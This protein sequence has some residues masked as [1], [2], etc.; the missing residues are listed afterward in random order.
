[1]G[2][3]TGHVTQLVDLARAFQRRGWD[4]RFAL[5]NPDALWTLAPELAAGVLPAPFHQPTAEETLSGPT[6]LLY[7][8]ELLG[9]GWETE[10]QL[11]R[12]VQGWQAIFDATAPTVLVS[13]AAPTALLAARGRDILTVN[14]GRGYD[15]PPLNTPMWPLAYWKSVTLAD[16]QARE[17]VAVAS[18]NALLRQQGL[19]PVPDF[20]TV[21]RA[22]LS[23]R[24][25]FAE[26]SHYPPDYHPEPD[27]HLGPFYRLDQGE[28]VHWLAGFRYRVLVYLQGYMPGTLPTLLALHRLPTDHDVVFV[29]P[30]MPPH[31][32]ARLTKPNIRLYGS[33]VRFDALL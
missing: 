15:V 9:C 25:D 3:A 13:Q 10:A 1:M 16:R 31:I 2:K 5:R 8:D 19:A 14:L 18:V 7:F 29:C 26:L 30:G 17:D 28:E 22:D 27:A 33:A 21:L 23:L 20:A 6:P 11:T 32:I 24:C 12:L 4:V